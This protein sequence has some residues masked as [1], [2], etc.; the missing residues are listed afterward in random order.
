MNMKLKKKNVNLF[1]QFVEIL[2]AIFGLILS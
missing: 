2:P 1:I